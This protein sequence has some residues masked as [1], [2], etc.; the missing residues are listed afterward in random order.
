MADK[1][2]TTDTKPAGESPAP[3]SAPTPTPPPRRGPGHRGTD[4]RDAMAE[5]AAR[6]QEISLEAGSKVA[7]AMREVIYAAAGIAGFAVESARD[8]VQYMVRRGQMSQEDADKLIREAEEAN[9]RRPKTATAAV[10]PA[11][12]PGVVETSGAPRLGAGGAAV[13]GRL[14]TRPEGR[15]EIRGAAEARPSAAVGSAPRIAQGRPAP[16]PAPSVAKAAPKAPASRGESKGAAR[17]ATK[18]AATAAKGAS[19]AAARGA[20][21]SASGSAKRTS[22]GAAT[23]RAG[24]TSKPAKK[25]ARRR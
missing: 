16:A 24:R 18:S 11:S 3:A 19:K 8:L 6:A 4:A 14:A 23:G 25:S 10:R 7:A 15:P 20:A 2:Q 21:R 13:E 17:V 1:P 5:M 22:K 9:A 12:V